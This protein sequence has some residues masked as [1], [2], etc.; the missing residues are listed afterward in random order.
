LNMEN[1]TQFCQGSI[2]M[3]LSIT[4]ASCI[5]GFPSE[6]G[7]ISVFGT[8]FPYWGSP[9][10]CF[11]SYKPSFQACSAEAEVAMYLYVLYINRFSII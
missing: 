11:L 7:T 6:G 2:F 4:L 9:K 8:G 1:I 5:V 10:S 3:N